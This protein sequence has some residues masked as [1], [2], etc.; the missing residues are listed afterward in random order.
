MKD[1]NSPNFSNQ[2]LRN[3]S[4]RSKALN[5]VDF[6]GSDIRGCD[7]SQAQLVAARFDRA[8][9]G[10]TNRQIFPPILVSGIF[11]FALAQGAA[12][13]IFAS[14]GQAPSQSAWVSS[15][16][17]HLFLGGAA[18]GAA[19]PMVLGFN[20]RVGRLGIYLSGLFSGAL[21]LFFYAGSYFN[22]NSQA[23]IVGVV[24]GAGLMAALSWVARRPMAVSIL[25]MGAVAAYG[26]AFL[27]WTTA[28]A[29]LTAKHYG[30][31]L[32]LGA[33]SL[34]YGWVAV[35]SVGGMGQAI[36]QLIGTS[37][38]GADLTNAQFEQANLKNTD[39]S[40]AIGRPQ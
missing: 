30:L 31:G 13:L 12:Q 2:D 39:F 16:I 28:I 11:A 33:I 40:K 4:F 25:A 5:E 8:R 17:L 29:Y 3:R 37:F 21:T 10:Q 1:Q 27:T 36:S 32:G 38:R 26:F 18:T 9:T 14:L 20:S 6:S 22:N 35:C 23:A 15:V 19:S 34:A 24:A 7:F